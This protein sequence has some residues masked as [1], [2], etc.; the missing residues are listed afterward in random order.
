[1]MEH[2]VSVR[3]MVTWL[4]W[5]SGA[6]AGLLGLAIENDD[7]A[8]LGMVLTCAGMMMVVLNDNARTRRLIRF[9]IREAGES[10]R[11]PIAGVPRA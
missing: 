8:R 10:P 7:L 3:C 1:M 9:G 11:P 6:A 2:G 5:L 4:A